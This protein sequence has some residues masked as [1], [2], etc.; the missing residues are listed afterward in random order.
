M[1]NF[2]NF[3]P[4]FL[5]IAGCSSSSQYKT[6]EL[7]GQ[8]L[9][10]ATQQYTIYAGYDEVWAACQKEMSRFPLEISNKASGVII[11]KNMKEFYSELLS[12]SL[13]IKKQSISKYDLKVTPLEFGANPKTKV[14]VTRFINKV[15]DFGEVLGPMMSSGVQE[16]V[17]LYRVKRLIDLERKINFER[18]RK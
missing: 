7:F 12:S 18:T 11:T 6:T 2:L 9:T 16:K 5:I 15:G 17:I 10:P 3:I 4:I 14:E 13:D 8:S 1:R